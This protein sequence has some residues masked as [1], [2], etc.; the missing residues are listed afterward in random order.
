MANLALRAMLE[1]KPGKEDAVREFLKSALPLVEGEPGTLH[2]YALELET[3]QFAIFDTFHDEAGRQA[4]L[5]GEV[6]K[7]LFARADKLFAK[8][9]HVD[10]IEILAEK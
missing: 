8:P 5:N 3:G 10:Q 1:A 4:H 2:W 9:P 6:A 7:A